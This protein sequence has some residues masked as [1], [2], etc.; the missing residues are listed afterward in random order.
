MNLNEIVD[1]TLTA[2]NKRL[3]LVASFSFIASITSLW[4]MGHTWAYGPPH[5]TGSFYIG[6]A[7]V[8]FA[9]WGFIFVWTAILWW[10]KQ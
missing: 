1:K 2:W 7:G 5:P 4:F 6:I 9:F 10:N 8:S 3:G